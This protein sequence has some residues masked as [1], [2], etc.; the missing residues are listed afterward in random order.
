M[1]S[2]SSFERP[3][4]SPM[5]IWFINFEPM[6]PKSGSCMCTPPRADRDDVVGG[7]RRPANASEAAASVVAIMGAAS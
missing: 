3:E 6:S 2:D 1:A 4:L 7:R 5:P